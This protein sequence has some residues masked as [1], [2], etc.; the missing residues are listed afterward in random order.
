MFVSLFQAPA[1]PYGK[2]RLA[3]EADP[4]QA[5]PQPTQPGRDQLGGPAA[6][7]NDTEEAERRRRLFKEETSYLSAAY[8]L[9][10]VKSRLTLKMRKNVEEDGICL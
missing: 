4:E 10:N 5:A 9:C 7:K 6:M 8:S 3:D 1:P 2:L